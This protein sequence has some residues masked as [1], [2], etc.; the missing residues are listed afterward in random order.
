MLLRPPQR[1][2]YSLVAARPLILWVPLLTGS[3]YKETRLLRLQRRRLTLCALRRRRF[4]ERCARPLRRHRQGCNVRAAPRA[5]PLWLLMVVEPLR[6]EP[7]VDLCSRTSGYL[8]MPKL[9]DPG[10][11]NWR[12]LAVIGLSDTECSFWGL[13]AVTSWW[14]L[15]PALSGAPRASAARSVRPSHDTATPS[16]ALHIFPDN[17]DTSCCWQFL[18][19]FEG[20]KPPLIPELGFIEQD[21]GGPDLFVHRNEVS[22]GGLLDGDDVQFDEKGNLF[23]KTKAQDGV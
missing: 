23:K 2:M 4:L 1:P 9:P 3:L 7:E 20:G 19:F 17:V 18:V 6:G 12:L 5:E 10:D 16:F 13:A 11:E 21:N 14:R 15:S 22:G 8:W